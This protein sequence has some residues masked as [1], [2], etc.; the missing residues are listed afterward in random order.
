M[1]RP[2]TLA[3]ARS[4]AGITL[5]EILISIMIMGIGLTSLA[6]LF[7]IGLD[8]IRSA[9]RMTRSTQLAGTAVSDLRSRGLLR[10]EAF[11]ANYWFTTNAAGTQLRDPWMI[12]FND[13]VAI[14]IFA[15][16]EGLPVAYDPLWWAM[17][18]ATDETVTPGTGVNTSP[19]LME[20]RF[21]AD[22]QGHLRTDPMGGAASAY[23][24]QRITTLQF[25]QPKV[26]ASYSVDASAAIFTSPDDPILLTEGRVATDA[27]GDPVPTTEQGNTTLPML[28]NQGT[29]YSTM[30]DWAYTWMFTG[31]RLGLNDLTYAGD[32]VVF[33]NRPLSVDTVGGVA[34]PTGERVVEAIFAYGTTVNEFPHPTLRT[35]G[36][37]PQDRTVLIRWPSSQPDPTLRVGSWIADVTYERYA[38][39]DILRT[40]NLFDRYPGQRCHWYRVSRRTEPEADPDVSNHRRMILTT[41]ERV[42]SRTL[43]WADDGSHEG[44]DPVRL[45][46]ALINPYVVNVLKNQVIIAK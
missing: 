4:R 12:D 7:P 13:G 46:A 15:R 22:V 37:S 2:A 23:G 29:S 24:L 31:K 34:V 16:V 28:V 9:Q 43:L 27:S 18:S 36:Y 11:S 1:M 3:A 19:R 45:N 35:Y 14:P 6:T 10:R 33:H 5:T 20:G 44:G 21:A 39:T 32:V 17:V 40:L 26:A 42:A 38:P 41:D 30:N 8:R 25:L